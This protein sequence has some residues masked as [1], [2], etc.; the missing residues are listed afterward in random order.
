MKFRA[1][2][3]AFAVPSLSW[4]ATSLAEIDASRLTVV[5]NYS[6]PASNL[7][8]EEEHPLTPGFPHASLLKR[9]GVL[10]YN[11]AA[12]TAGHLAP[13]YDDCYDLVMDMAAEPD[14]TLILGPLQAEKY[15]IGT[16]EVEVVN[17]DRCENV[18]VRWGDI[19]RSDEPSLLTTMLG[20]PAQGLYAYIITTD[21]TVAL[22]MSTYEDGYLPTYQEACDSNPNHDELRA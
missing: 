18:Q 7:A 13:A 15:F 4:P 16:C 6:V 8:S 3:L 14:R 11:F 22:I 17:L 12:P 10:T 20:G 21:P 5:S 9:Y 1:F 19:A 2:I